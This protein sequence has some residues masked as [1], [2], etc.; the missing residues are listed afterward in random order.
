MFKVDPFYVFV[1]SWFGTMGHTGL[2]T[3]IKFY[4]SMNSS[5][6]VMLCVI[7]ANRIW[8]HPKTC[9]SQLK[10]CTCKLGEASVGAFLTLW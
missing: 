8:P 9:G 7:M 2:H 3:S 1:F 4:G 10:S 5:P 6:V